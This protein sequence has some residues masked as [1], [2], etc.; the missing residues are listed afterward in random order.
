M[1][2]APVKEALETEEGKAWLSSL[3]NERVAQEHSGMLSKM[4]EL[5][6]EAKKAKAARDEES[7]AKARAQEEAALKSGDAEK[8]KSLWESEKESKANLERQLRSHVVDSAITSAL[9]KVNVAAPL[10]D[11][12]K[13]YLE[14][15]FTPEIMVDNGK[16]YAVMGGKPVNDFIQEW[17]AGEQGKHFVAAPVNSGGGSGGANASAGGAGGKT[18][19]LEAY[20]TLNSTNPYAATAFL[21]S[22]GTLTE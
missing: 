7:K 8:I 22:G 2:L 1:D 14:R 18:M 13:A 5:M 20:N 9:A 16:P 15:T 10:M 6:D 19:T 3:V 21:N 17:A 11:A 4:N 12:A